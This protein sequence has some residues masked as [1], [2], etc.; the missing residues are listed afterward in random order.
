MLLTET[1]SVN[2]LIIIQ[3]WTQLT[4]KLLENTGSVSQ[5]LIQSDLVRDTTS[6]V[7]YPSNI[8]LFLKL[9]TYY[10]FEKHVSLPRHRKCAVTIRKLDYII[11]GTKKNPVIGIEGNASF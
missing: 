6:C 2:H 8:S 11:P 3:S 5:I 9:L 7:K 4:H 10:T 1:Y